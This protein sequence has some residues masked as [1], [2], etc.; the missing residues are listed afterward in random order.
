MGRRAIKFIIFPVAFL[1]FFSC[2]KKMTEREIFDK[3]QK[4][5]SENKFKKSA[6]LYEK[7][8]KD[9]P[10]SKHYPSS[11]FML[12]FLYANNIK[13]YDKARKYYEEFLKKFPN[14]E[15]ADDVEFELKNLGKPISEIDNLIKETER[16]QK[17]KK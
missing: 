17:N 1:L 7:L 8:L 9:Y 2:G 16:N 12:G 15:L 11:L 5:Q 6:K 14:H 10:E 4:L 3:A 13:D